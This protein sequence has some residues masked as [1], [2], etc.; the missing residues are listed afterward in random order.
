MNF[1]DLFHVIELDNIYKHYTP[2]MYII[3]TGINIFIS[4]YTRLLYK[5]KV[6]N[7]KKI[8]ITSIYDK[9]NSIIVQ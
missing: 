4:V 1:N 6:I 3:Y 8:Q 5:L 9:T 2:S 7:Y